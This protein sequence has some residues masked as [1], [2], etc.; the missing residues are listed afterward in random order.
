MGRRDP[1]KKEMV[2]T[3]VIL[4]GKSHDEGSEWATVQESDTAE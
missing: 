3:V 2:T 1:L 4:P